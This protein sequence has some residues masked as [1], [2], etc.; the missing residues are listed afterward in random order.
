MLKCK[1]YLKVIS[2]IL[3]FCFFSSNTSW[4]GPAGAFA[5]LAAPTVN[6]AAGEEKINSLTKIDLPED[7]GEIKRVFESGSE[8]TV[9]HIQDAHANYEAQKNIARLIDYFRNESN[10]SLVNVEGSA[11]KLYTEAVSNYPSKAARGAVAETYLKKAMITGPEFLVI[12]ENPDVDLFGA[13]TK[14]LYLKNKKAFIDALKFKSYCQKRLYAVRGALEALAKKVYSDEL[15]RLKEERDKFKRTEELSG[16]LF[17]LLALAEEK[18]LDCSDLKNIKRFE[19]L[20]EIDAEAED[21]ASRDVRSLVETIGKTLKGDERERFLS[22]SGAYNA[23]SVPE[24]EY[25]E[26]LRNT[27]ENLRL[28]EMGLSGVV[29]R[30]EYEMLSEA[31]DVGIFDEAETLSRALKESIFKSEMEKAVS[32]L[33]ENLEILEDIFGFSLTKKGMEYYYSHKGEFKIE[34]FRSFINENREILAGNRFAKLP[35]GLDIIDKCREKIEGFYAAAVKRDTELVENSLRQMEERGEKTSILITGGFHTPGIEKELK[36]RGISYVVV[37]PMFSDI[38]E[39]RDA[40]LYEESITRGAGELDA[41]LASLRNAPKRKRINDPRYQMAAASLFETRSGAAEING[42]AAAM[43]SL[44]EAIEFY[45]GADEKKIAGFRDFLRNAL[46]NDLKKS[47]LKREKIEEALENLNEVLHIL[48][49][50]LAFQRD[51]SGAR[52]IMIATKN[53]EGRRILV[54][55]SEKPLTSSVERKIIPLDVEPCRDFTVSVKAQEGSRNIYVNFYSITEGEF[56]EIFEKETTS[57]ASSLG[58]KSSFERE[59]EEIRVKVEVAKEKLEAEVRKLKTELSGIKEDILE[60]ERG[61]EAAKKEGAQKLEIVGELKNRRD[62]L[63]GRIGS[64]RAEQRKIL[65][66]GE[67]RARVAGLGDEYKDFRSAPEK[68]RFIKRLF[69]EFNR[70][71]ASVTRSIALA[72]QEISDMLE[73][74]LVVFEVY[75]TELANA[76]KISAAKEKINRFFRGLDAILKQVIEKISAIKHEIGN[77]QQ[78]LEDIKSSEKREEYQKRKLGDARDSLGKAEKWRNAAEAELQNLNSGIKKEFGTFASEHK[79]DDDIVVGL[80]GHF[81]SCRDGLVAKMKSNKIEET[82]KWINET[83]EEVKR[84]IS[85]RSEADKKEGLILKLKDKIKQKTQEERENISE[86]EKQIGEMERLLIVAEGKSETSEAERPSIDDSKNAFRDILDIMYQVEEGLTSLGA[87]SLNVDLSEFESLGETVDAL[88]NRFEQNI[89]GKITKIRERKDEVEQKTDRLANVLAALS[90]LQ[91]Q[92]KQAFSAANEMLAFGAVREGLIVDCELALELVPDINEEVIANN[93]EDV[94]RAEKKLEVVSRRLRVL[95]EKSKKLTAFTLPEELSEYSDD[96]RVKDFRDEIE[97]QLDQDGIR[98]ER[99]SEVEKLETRMLEKKTMIRAVKTEA[100]KEYAGNVPLEFQDAAERALAEPPASREEGKTAVQ[101]ALLGELGKIH[102]FVA[103]NP[104]VTHDDMFLGAMLPMILMEVLQNW[105]EHQVAK[106]YE[107]T[108]ELPPAGAQLNIERTG[109]GVVATIFEPGSEFRYRPKFGPVEKEM[110]E[111]GVDAVLEATRKRDREADRVGNIGMPMMVKMQM[112]GPDEVRLDWHEEYIEGLG[113]VRRLEFVLPVTGGEYIEREKGRLIEAI[114][115][116][117]IP[118]DRIDAAIADK[119]FAE[120]ENIIKNARQELENLADKVKLTD[121]YDSVKEEAAEPVRSAN[122][123]IAANKKIAAMYI[124]LEEYKVNLHKKAEEILKDLT[125]L[126]AKMAAKEIAEA[127]PLADKVDAGLKSAAEQI[128]QGDAQFLEREKAAP[129]S[130]VEKKQAVDRELSL[131]LREIEETLKEHKASIKARR[132]E[133]KI[134]DEIES[135]MNRKREEIE[136]RLSAVMST[137]GDAEGAEKLQV[138]RDAVS[139]N[140]GQDIPA[141]KPEDY[142][143]PGVD[144]VV[145]REAVLAANED[146]RERITAGIPAELQALKKKVIGEIENNISRQKTIIIA[147][148]EAVIGRMDEA[149]ERIKKEKAKE[150]IDE[151]ELKDLEE[152]MSMLRNQAASI[153]DVNIKIELDEESPSELKQVLNDTKD[154]ISGRKHVL[155]EQQAEL[156]WRYHKLRLKQER[157]VSDRVMDGVIAELDEV[158]AAT[159]KQERALTEVIAFV[160]ELLGDPRQANEASSLG[161]GRTAVIEGVSEIEDL[162]S[163]SRRM[164]L[165]NELTKKPLGFKLALQVAIARIVKMASKGVIEKESLLVAEPGFLSARKIEDKKFLDDYFAGTKEHKL[166]VMGVNRNVSIPATYIGRVQV[167]SEVNVEALLR[168]LASDFPN[169]NIGTI[170]FE[171]VSAAPDGVF[172]VVYDKNSIGNIGEIKEA[173]LCAGRDVTRFGEAVS[174]K[175][176]SDGVEREGESRVF[177]FTIATVE[178]LLGTLVAEK[179]GIEKMAKSA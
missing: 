75:E 48:S 160:T 151:K 27:A 50:D 74:L 179:A 17:Y 137:M 175:L 22:Y 64:F 78:S 88:K 134:L 170:G 70:V 108:G 52:L 25:Y 10:V 4:V 157:I 46:R 30:L 141:L 127:A 139:E 144:E 55:L 130:L 124:E 85:G 54:A 178:R 167:T 140:K 23:G 164:K 154:T 76:D 67:E 105:A 162:R 91:A 39:R 9:I 166:V 71:A 38:D 56:A 84:E 44:F 26:Y 68:S 150:E 14:E 82:M 98:K 115:G 168:K 159:E 145:I 131:A 53:I 65:E 148:I 20:N 114:V 59:E 92:A 122:E 161:T 36:K 176:L 97:E 58:R 155:S 12:S 174:Y 6:L 111:K 61:L 8:K 72:D 7:A 47:K 129:D 147:R 112:A 101:T 172:Q 24:K 177:R 32:R 173:A 33:L 99:V 133:A 37:A 62:E 89:N 41:L 90:S 135:W 73:P 118:V 40:R 163:A 143:Q 16:Y 128:K 11:G 152:N 87:F 5:Y 106:G 126:N 2:V 35:D 94:S 93:P 169:T 138:I 13:E 132:E 165:R 95:K 77:A 113:N 86:I 119:S 15:L 153:V 1:K 28:Q 109:S 107:A 31:I 120:A 42:T 3:F 43:L 142:I 79:I 103:G 121:A 34:R 125:A 156:E 18:N 81:K 171:E 146:I 100:S 66:R 45:G 69:R 29:A 96:P 102:D 158:I 104:E 149:Q 136:S 63:N 21:A 110:R 80:L 117:T 123:E 49:E 19:R 83:I 60:F 116:Y 51:E 57:S